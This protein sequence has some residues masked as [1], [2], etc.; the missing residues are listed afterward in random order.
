ME[1]LFLISGI[2]LLL[3]LL[4]WFL[5][6][7]FP[8][9]SKTEEIWPRLFAWVFF[10]TVLFAGLLF[11][12]PAQAQVAYYKFALVIGAALLGYWID[13]AIFPYSRPDGYLKRFWQDGSEEPMG[14]ADFEVVNEYG[15]VF[16]SAMIRRAIIIAATILGVTLGL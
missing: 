15:H 2:V 7:F 8:G 5:L 3:C 11:I 1:K 4:S 13:R 16:A 12:A 9:R 10:T 6:R 14:R